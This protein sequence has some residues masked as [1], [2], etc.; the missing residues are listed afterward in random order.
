MEIKDNWEDTFFRSKL[1]IFE[2]M[3]IVMK[4]Y[5]QIDYVSTNI[6]AN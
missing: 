4:Y 5:T 3:I 2:K 6:L 1:L